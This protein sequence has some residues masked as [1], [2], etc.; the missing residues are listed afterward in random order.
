MNVIFHTISAIGVVAMVTDTDMGKPAA[1]GNIRIVSVIALLSAVF[2]HGVLDYMPH[3]YPIHSKWDVIA[4]LCIIIAGT[5]VV[6]KPYQPIV[7]AAFTGCILPDLIDLLP[8]IL[9]KYLGWRLPAGQKIFPWHWKE[10]SGSVYTGRCETSLINHLA[11]VLFVLF[12]SYS[13]RRDL[14]QLLK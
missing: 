1:T 4:G 14:K 11:V 6:R 3:C 10:N 13:R 9:N 5:L 8:P 2:L 12:I 7:L